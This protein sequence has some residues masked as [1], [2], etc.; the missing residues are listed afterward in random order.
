MP[1]NS[2]DKRITFGVILIF[3][4]GLFL[5]NTFDIL[6]FRVS[7]IIFSGPFILFM[8]GILIFNKLK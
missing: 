6:D 4:G 7:K 8:V 3:I 2:I 1:N 5:L